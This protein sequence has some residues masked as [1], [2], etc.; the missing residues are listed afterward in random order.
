MLEPL[1]LSTIADQIYLAASEMPG[2]AVPILAEKLKISATEA[3]IGYQELAGNGLSLGDENQVIV[4][5]PKRA[6]E[7]LISRQEAELAMRK[8]HAQRLRE[9]LPVF[10]DQNSE[11]ERI[12]GLEA[13]RKRLRLLSL[14]AER[15]VATF[16]PGGAH[17]PESLLEARTVDEEV[18]TRGVRSRAIFLSSM[19]NDNRTLKHVTWLNERGA[20]VRTTPALPIRMIVQDKKIAV[21]P[22]DLTNTKLGI[23]IY[24]NPSA[25]LAF[26]SL[27]ESTWATATPL[28]NTS[29]VNEHGLSSDEKILLEMLALGRTNEEIKMQMGLSERSVR[30][31][32]ESL[33]E[34]LGAKSRFSGGYLAVK[35]GWI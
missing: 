24:H 27:F 14:E 17:R 6:I 30:R 11:I 34:R 4:P 22:L 2:Q 26:Q 35:N 9:S 29:M 21:L 20:E 23:A 10:S 25:V 8:A 15:E 19:R 16:A 7:I 32:I 31:K 12:Q 3:I 13:T 33:L 18:L 5:S 1:G 28:G